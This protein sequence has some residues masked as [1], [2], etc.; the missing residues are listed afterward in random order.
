[1]AHTY[2]TDSAER[3]YI[4]LCIAAAAI[5]GAFLTFHYLKKHHIDMPWWFG[6]PDTMA[7]YGLFYLMFDR[8]VWKF[9]P[10]RW[11]AITKVPD[12]SGKWHGKVEPAPTPGVSAGLAAPKDI[13]LTI[14]QTWT[15]LLVSAQTEQ[16]KSR[17]LSGAIVVADEMSLSY[18]F[19]N[20]PAAPAPPTMHAHRGVARLILNA[21]QTVLEGEYY[22]GRDRQN[23][24]AIR[25][26]RSK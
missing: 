24:G 11:L 26:T 12:L 8:F 17:S 3:K 15:E 16:S 5:G 20:E 23:I 2:A 1:M 7:L 10:L 4:P 22:S 14:R 13:T 18:E 19:T 9:P 21:T 6:P 25:V